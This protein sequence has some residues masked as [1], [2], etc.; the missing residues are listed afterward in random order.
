MRWSNPAVAAAVD[1]LH[2]DRILGGISER[3]AQALNR[4][5][6]SEI[7]IDEHVAGPQSLPKFLARDDLVRTAQQKLQGAKGQVLDP[8][9]DSVSAQLIRAQVGLEHPEQYN[10]I[11]RAMQ[12]FGRHRTESPPARPKVYHRNHG[13]RNKLLLAS[14]AFQA[15]L[16]PH[17][18]GNNFAYCTANKPLSASHTLHQRITPGTLTAL[19]VSGHIRC[20][21]SSR[22]D[23]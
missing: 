20:R 11:G 4:A 8:D 2:K 19:H 18:P 14:P 3:V 1:S 13:R 22:E 21:V 5:A 16:T 9:L 23:T 6:D 15:C 7:E 12:R 17:S 10:R